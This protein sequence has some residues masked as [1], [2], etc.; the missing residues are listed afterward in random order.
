MRRV[1]SNFPAE[2]SIFYRGAFVADHYTVHFAVQVGFHTIFNIHKRLL[3]FEAKRRTLFSST[4][5]TRA[6]P[7]KAA[8]SALSP[9]WI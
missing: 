1:W 5:R 2:S 7:L 3:E 6:L 4:I 8:M 9:C